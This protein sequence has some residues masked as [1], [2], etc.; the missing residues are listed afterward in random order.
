METW[1]K[2]DELK[3]IVESLNKNEITYGKAIE[4]IT[5]KCKERAQ[6]SQTENGCSGCRFYNSCGT[7]LDYDNSGCHEKQL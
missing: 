2:I 3:P 7:R 5:E 1:I 6:S 4:L